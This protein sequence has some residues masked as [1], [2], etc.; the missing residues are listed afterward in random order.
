VL[1]DTAGALA[2]LPDA[3]AA[4]FGAGPLRHRTTAAPDLTKIAALTA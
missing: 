1:A 3:H 2:A 4:G